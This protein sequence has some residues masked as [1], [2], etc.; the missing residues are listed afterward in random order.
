M[1]TRADIISRAATWLTGNGGGPVA[2]SMHQNFGG[3]RADC[4]GYVSMAWQLDA[5]QFWWTG[6]LAAAGIP[7]TMADLGAGDMLLFHNPANPTSGS[8]VVLFERWAGNVGGDFWMYE[9]TPPHTRHRRWSDTSGRNLNNYLPYRYKGL[10]PD[11]TEGDADMRGVMGRV[12]GRLT[13]WYGTTAHGHTRPLGKEASVE[14][15]RQAGAVFETFDTAAGL[16]EV[17]GWQAGDTDGSRTL[18]A[19]NSAA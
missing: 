13:V 12:H 2:Y 19:V 15:L 11:P 1:F 16:I 3:R 4:S 14:V 17:L 18:A 6:T 10:Q 5:A 8:H 9:Q 7:I